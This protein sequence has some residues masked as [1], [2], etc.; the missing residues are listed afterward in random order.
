MATSVLPLTGSRFIDCPAM[1]NVSISRCNAPY[2]FDFAQSPSPQL[3][4]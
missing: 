1:T 2:Q 4:D 3:M